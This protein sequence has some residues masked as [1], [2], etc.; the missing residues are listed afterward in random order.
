M[1]ISPPSLEI[2]SI[3]DSMFNTTSQ[4]HTFLNPPSP[5]SMSTR[6]QYSFDTPPISWNDLV[7]APMLDEQDYFDPS[8]M[9]S[10]SQMLYDDV[11]L[12]GILMNEGEVPSPNERL[13]PTANQL[14]SPSGQSS[15]EST[16]P[17]H[18]SSME[19]R[20]TST[21][22]RTALTRPKGSCNRCKKYRVS[23]NLV[24]FCTLNSD[25]FPTNRLSAPY[26]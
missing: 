24:N 3:L 21:R 12:R 23:T 16:L 14:D 17:A 9:L 5:S 22:K 13:S 18:P 19:K 20:S 6:T 2:P 4:Q 26:L 25:I 15:A 8:I 1:A 7:P 10:A 11:E